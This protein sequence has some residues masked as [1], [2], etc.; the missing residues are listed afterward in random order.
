M[1]QTD[2]K[3]TVANATVTVD[4]FATNHELELRIAKQDSAFTEAI[5]VLA[6]C[7]GYA[8]G[9]QGK[10]SQTFLDEQKVDWP[11]T[12][13]EWADFHNLYLLAYAEGKGDRK[14]TEVG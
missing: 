11:F 5:R 4:E 10:D 6:D 7:L 3:P 8:H 9:L 14:Q 1:V 2:G 13:A 12:S